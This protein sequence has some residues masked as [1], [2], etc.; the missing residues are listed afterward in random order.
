[1]PLPMDGGTPKT[2]S[3]ADPVETL[4][5][6][7][8]ESPLAC[9]YRQTALLQQALASDK[10]RVGFFLGAGCPVSIRV[11]SGAKTVP[12][13]PNIEGLTEIIR[14][15]MASSQ[16]YNSMYSTIFELSETDEFGKRTIEHVLTKIRSLVDA[17]GEKNFEGFSKKQLMDLDKQLCSEISTV[18]KKRLPSNATPYHQ[19]ASWINAIP[20]AHAVEIFTSNYDL[21]MEQALEECRVPYFDGFCGSDRTFFD[22]TAMEQDKLPSRW[23]RLWKVHGSINWW[24]STKD[25]IQRKHSGEEGELQMIHP[26][27]LKYLQSRM[28]PYLAM[29]DQLRAFLSR[30]QAVLVT[31]GYSFA[32]GHL[33]RAI[34]EGL[35]GNPTAVCFGLIFGDKEEAEQSIAQAGI[36]GNLRLIRVNGGVLGTI[37]RNWHSDQK[38]DDNFHGLAVNV[39]NMGDR[40]IAPDER[41]KFLLGDFKSFGQFLA[42]ELERRDYEIEGSN[43]K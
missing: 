39:G 30:G 40:T 25:E 12:L 14:L 36:P 32:D 4:P 6:I 22:S 20:R 31:C 15:K 10:M 2:G 5:P 29:Q 11:S 19:L 21:L 18:M 35:R 16:V 43:G 3:S 8:A 42:S 41:C 13:I 1:M 24:R 9:P 34:L 17:I 26:S 27:H 33:T 38:S 7:D 37:S 23:A 28:M